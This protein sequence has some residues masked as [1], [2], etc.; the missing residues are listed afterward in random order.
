MTQAPASTA[1]L[2]LP[3]LLI[4]AEEGACV[5]SFA[6]ALQWLRASASQARRQRARTTVGV[7]ID[8]L[9][10]RHFFAAED[11]RSLIDVSLPAGTYHVTVQL[12]GCSRR[13]TVTL[14]QGATVDLHLPP[15]ADLKPR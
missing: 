2:S 3:H 4:H 8:D 14:A 9:Q 11:A 1:P 12:G 7:R 10:G 5:G 15:A 6:F 13:Y